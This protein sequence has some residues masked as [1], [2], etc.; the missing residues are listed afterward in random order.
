MNI[1]ERRDSFVL[2]QGSIRIRSTLGALGK[3]TWTKE[4][5]RLAG[6]L[7]QTL[8]ALEVIKIFG[9]QS[10]VRTRCLQRY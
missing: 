4:L 3:K 9:N 1:A 8:P 10:S 6:S 2:K 7:Q 5:Q